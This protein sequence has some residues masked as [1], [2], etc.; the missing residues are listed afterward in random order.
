[1]LRAYGASVLARAGCGWL[2]EC[3]IL[4]VL[5]R[6]GHPPALR[7]LKLPYNGCCIAV[8]KRCGKLGSSACDA[9]EFKPLLEGAVS[10][11]QVAN[12]AVPTPAPTRD[13]S[14]APGG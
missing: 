11:W 6:R 7:A 1:M 8:S 10:R 3:Y 12:A 2:A 14:S 4:S 13:W 5:G 9:R